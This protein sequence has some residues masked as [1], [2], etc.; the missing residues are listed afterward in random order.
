MPLECLDYLLEKYGVAGIQATILKKDGSFEDA[1]AGLAEKLSGNDGRKMTP[2]TWTEL[3]SLSK[4]LAAAFTC[5]FAATRNIALDSPVNGLLREAGS[6]FRLE[7]HDDCDPQWA[8]E[9]TL[10]QLTN[11]TALG[12]HYVYGF[13]PDEGVPSMQRLLTGDCA[14]MGYD[15]LRVTKQ[16]GTAFKYSGGGFLTLQLLLETMEGKAI[17]AVMHSFLDSVGMSECRFDGTAPDGTEV[18][19]GYTDAG[20]VVPGTRLSFPGLA[21]GALGTAHGLARFW[22]HLMLA[23]A[24]S[25]DAAVTPSTARAMLASPVDLGAREFM[26]AEA[27][28]GVFIAEAGPNKIALHQAANDGFRGVYLVCFDGPNAG[29]G[30]V[31]L[32]NGGNQAARM[33]A[34][35]LRAY[36]VEA[37]WQGIDF[38]PTS[39]IN[40]DAGDFSTDGLTQA[41]IVNQTYKQLVFDAFEM[42]VCN[43][44]LDA[45]KFPRL[46]TDSTSTQTTTDFEIGWAM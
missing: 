20:E 33:L 13:P 11:H 36:L 32:A 34:E 38:E 18:A 25:T 43:S 31:A 17:D 26:N 2:T 5:E 30:I 10:A 4:T 39:P 23:Y 8:E 6:T 22:R 29:E 15:R 28:L 46:S 12:M 9:V 27:G 7:S 14:A 35:V 41:E 45:D 3:A 16:P 21:A 1:C 24:G 19:H 42:S 37:R 44:S 40:K